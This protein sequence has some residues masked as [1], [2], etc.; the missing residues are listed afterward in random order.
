[1]LGALSVATVAALTGSPNDLVRL[2][3]EELGIQTVRTAESTA[4]HYSAADVKRIT[5]HLRRTKA[6]GVDLVSLRA[7][8]LR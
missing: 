7:R 6:A 5:E 3:A 2:A 1:M 8:G 4:P